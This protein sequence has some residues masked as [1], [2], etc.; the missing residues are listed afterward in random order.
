MRR[1]PSTVV[2]VA[3]AA[4]VGL[5]LLIGNAAGQGNGRSTPSVVAKPTVITVTLGKPTE[6]AVKLSK[7][8]LIPAG[9]VIFKVTNAGAIGHNFKVCAKAFTAKALP[10]A[11]VGTQTKLLGKGK[12]QT[13]TLTLRKG[14]YEFLCSLSG[15]AK[16]GMKG[17]MGIGIKL[18]PS[19]TR[20]VP[21]PNPPAVT[22]TE[23][24]PAGQCA[25]PAPTTISLNIGEY[26]FNT[27]PRTIPCGNVTVNALNVGGDDHNFSFVGKAPGDVIRAGQ[28]GTQTVFLE[29]GTYVFQCNVGDHATR[30][31]SGSL[32]VT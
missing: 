14:Q 1:K 24:Q 15:H 30:G 7:K 28:M 17:L 3:A 27:V 22:P 20:L 5:S 21:S 4:A 18:S 31:M 6:F 10:D 13:L 9:K 11:C 2:V 23:Q 32:T 29:A 25:S 12:T 26:Y 19:V 8:E 16:N